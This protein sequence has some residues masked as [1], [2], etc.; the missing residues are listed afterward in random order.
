MLL[1]INIFES[2]I[3]QKFNRETRTLWIGG[4]YEQRWNATWGTWKTSMLS[5]RRRTF[6]R[7]YWGVEKIGIKWAIFLWW[8]WTRSKQ[9]WKSLRPTKAI[10][11]IYEEDRAFFC[12][13]ITPAIKYLNQCHSGERQNPGK[14]PGCRIRHSGPDTWRTWPARQVF[15]I[16]STV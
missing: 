5:S 15:P 11:P 12:G 1:A 2:I 10:V 7:Q 4:H 14:Q 8:L 13:V 3:I 16:S 9:L 6:K